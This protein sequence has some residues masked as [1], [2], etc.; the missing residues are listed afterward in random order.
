MSKM[1]RGRTDDSFFTDSHPSFAIL[2]P[3]S[4]AMMGAYGEDGTAL[5]LIARQEHSLATEINASRDLRVV[6]FSA[7]GEHLLSG[8][9]DQNVQVWRVQDGRRVATIQAVGIL[10]LAVSKNGKWM[11][12]GTLWGEVFIWD[13]ETH[14]RVWKH[15]EDTWPMEACMEAVDFSPDSTKLVSGSRNCTAT[16]WDLASGEKMWTFHHGPKEVIAAK[17]SSDGDRIATAT[18]KGSVRVRD[19]SNGQ[20]LVDIPVMVPSLYNNG[21]RWFDNHIFVVYGSTIKQLDA[22]TGSMV[23]EW[24]VPQSNFNSCIAIP[25]HGKFMA[26]STNHSVTFWDTSTHLQIGLVEHTEDICSI[27]LSPDNSSL[28]VGGENGTI[29]IKGLHHSIVS[30]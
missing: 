27:A 28:A 11:A 10:C 7:N 22:S 18:Y 14:E 23:Y 15:R 2:L 17:F 6:A 24:S 20:L 5:I 26:Y 13:A 21:L 12:G 25:I 16:L 30:T 9:R 19:S 29:I 8:G 4:L 3:M 1:R